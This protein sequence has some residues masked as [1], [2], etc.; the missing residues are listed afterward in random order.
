MVMRIPKDAI[1]AGIGMAFQHFTLIPSLTVAE[2]IA[3]AATHAHVFMRR[4]P[5]ITHVQELRA[6]YQLPVDPNSPMWQFSVSEQQRVEIL[7]LLHRRACLLIL[8]EPS[9]VLTPQESEVLLQT[10]RRLANASYAVI[11]ITH[12]LAEALTAA[13]R[14]TVLSRGQVV[15]NPDPARV[16]K[17]DLARWMIGHELSTPPTRVS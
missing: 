4:K 1:R 3:L 11:P 13:H 2:N 14:I 12:R 15:A 16:T 17:S 5:L 10:L 7:K 8:D 9:A 6:H